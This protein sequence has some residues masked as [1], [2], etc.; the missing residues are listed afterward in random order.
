MI[1]IDELIYDSKKGRDVAHPIKLDYDPYSYKTVEAAA[2]GLGAALTKLATKMGQNASEVAVFDPQRSQEAGTG[3]GWRVIWEAGP[4]DW[5]IGAS[6][7]ITGPW[8]YTEPYYGFDL[9][10]VEN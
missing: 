4:Y 9:C 2:K 5:A 1:T 7:K 10:F 3:K 6:F 8:G